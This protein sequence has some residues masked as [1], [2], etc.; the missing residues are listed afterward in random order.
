MGAVMDEVPDDA[1]QRAIRGDGTTEDEWNDWPGLARLP[2]ID[3]GQL[4]PEG[5]RAVVVAPHPDDE[6]LAV[7]AGFDQTAQRSGGIGGQPEPLEGVA[8]EVFRHG[9]S[10]GR[11]PV[12][13]PRT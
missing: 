3:S 12:D 4:V 10:C 2:A 1:A 9:S 11:V 7:G 6:V 13:G 8:A 5:A